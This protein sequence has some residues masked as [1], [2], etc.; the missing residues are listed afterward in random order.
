MTKMTFV[1]AVRDFQRRNPDTGRG[2]ENPI[3]KFARALHEAESRG[4]PGFKHDSVVVAT[5]SAFQCIVHK[6]RTSS[7]VEVL[8]QDATSIFIL[9]RK[10]QLETSTTDPVLGR[11]IHGHNR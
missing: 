4:V 8:Y 11:P 10:P 2:I 9:D 7:D 3:V 6:A 5:E 1:E